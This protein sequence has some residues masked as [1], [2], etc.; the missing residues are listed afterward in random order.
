M[1]GDDHHSI[2]RLGVVLKTV[3]TDTVE[4]AKQ[5][6]QQRL[7]DLHEFVSI[8]NLSLAPGALREK[9]AVYRVCWSIRSIAGPS[10]VLSALY[11]SVPPRSWKADGRRES[12][13]GFYCAKKPV[14]ARGESF[15]LSAVL[16]TATTPGTLWEVRA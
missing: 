3:D 9:A 11:C 16:L 10:C 4:F 5:P 12:Y 7:D 15:W 13:M 8:R 1:V 2:T 6:A 14:E